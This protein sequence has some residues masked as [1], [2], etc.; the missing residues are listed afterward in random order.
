VAPGTALAKIRR[1]FGGIPSG[2]PPE[3]VRTPEAPQ[4]GERRVELEGGGTTSYFHVAYRAPSVREEDVYPLVV[5]DAVLGGAKGISLWSFDGEARRSSPLHRKMV[6]SRI[7]TAARSFYIPTRDPFLYY[8]T[9]TAAEG[10]GIDKVERA[11]F[12]LIDSIASKKPTARE[13][14]K[15]KNQIRAT[16]VFQSDSVTEVAH[17]LGYFETIHDY[18]FFETFLHRIEAVT[19]EQVRD[20]ASR[21][22][23]RNNRTVG[24]YRPKRNGRNG[25]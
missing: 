5:L 18:A 21:L 19:A 17:Q 6:D 12:R 20:V 14:R 9:V 23:R 25:R 2:R 11:L 1:W 7:A 15:A 22:L 4:R 8:F 10:I 24:V 13:M 16:H 3:R